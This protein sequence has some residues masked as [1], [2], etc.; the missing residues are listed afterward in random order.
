MHP[1]RV[2]E[3]EILAF[4]KSVEEGPVTLTPSGEPQDIYAGHV[5]YTAS[6][7]WVVT[8]FNDCNE[9]DYIE[10]L[11]TPD[12]RECCYDQI[13]D[14]M[15][16]VDAYSPSEEVAW[17]R[18]RIPGYCKFRCVRCGEFIEDRELIKLPYICGR[19]GEGH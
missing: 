8:I 3:A 14:F 16:Q 1:S 2:T 10:H 7:G 17:E 5:E 6:N 12:G 19:C 18:W 13:N 4:L 11:R 15:P 9:W